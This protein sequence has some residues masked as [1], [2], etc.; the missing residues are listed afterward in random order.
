MNCLVPGVDIRFASGEAKHHETLNGLSVW[1]VSNPR[2]SPVV[3]VDVKKSGGAALCFQNSA[4]L[5]KQSSA[6]APCSPTY[7]PQKGTHRFALCSP[8]RC[9]QV[10]LGDLGSYSLGFCN[11]I[12]YPGEIVRLLQSESLEGIEGR[13]SRLCA[14]LGSEANARSYLGLTT[15][16]LIGEL[17]ADGVVDQPQRSNTIVY[18]SSLGAQAF[19]YHLK[20]G[21][22]P[23]LSDQEKLCLRGRTTADLRVFSAAAQKGLSSCKDLHT[24]LLVRQQIAYV[25]KVL[26]LRRTHAHNNLDGA[27][28]AFFSHATF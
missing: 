17:I 4:A 2:R 7:V 1:E 27:D 16:D 25:G 10:S 12:S 11:L 22:L 13:N 5:G 6:S 3:I 19:L 26:K 23:E 18:A 8:D 15:N 24:F 9:S 21:R 14:I 28:G 20:G